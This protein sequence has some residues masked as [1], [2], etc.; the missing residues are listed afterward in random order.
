MKNN[1]FSSNLNPEDMIGNMKYYNFSEAASKL[2]VEGVGRNTLL[3]IMREKGIFD[4]FNVPTPEWEHHPFFK[5]VE[6]KHL[7]PLISEHG[8]NYIRRNFF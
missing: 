7:T 2:N 6:N 4:R 8:I 1:M 5:N 3:K